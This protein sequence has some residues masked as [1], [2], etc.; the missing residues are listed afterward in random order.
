MTQRLSAERLERMRDVLGGFVDRGEMPGLVA[1]VSRGADAHVEAIGALAFGG[2]AMRRDAIFRIA[3]M[4]KPV[5]A[6]AAMILVEECKLR[7]DDAV[8]AF[9]PELANRRVL[10]RLDGPLDDTVP[11]ARA[12]T[13]RDLLTFRCGVGAVMLPPGSVP[14]QK[15]MEEAGLA[16]GPDRVAHTPDSY[17]KSL[18]A[19]PLMHQ[20]G[21]RWMYHTGSD[22]LGVLITRASGESF[23]QFLRTRIFA[24]LSMKDTDFHVPAEKRDRLTTSYRRDPAGNA[25]IV[26]D[27]PH[28]SRWAEQPAFASGGGGLVSTADDYLAFCRMMLAKGRHGRT[29]VLSR[30]AVELM[31]MDHLTDAQKAGMEMFFGDGQGGFKSGWGF[32]MGIDTKRADLS[33]VPGRFGWTGGIGTAGLAD[34]K[35]DLV[36]VLLT[37][38]MMESPVLPKVMADFWTLAYQT[39]E[40]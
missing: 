23:A 29:R 8:D 17:M 5:T 37:Q 6:A 25:L 33:S 2:A 34:P 9:L 4:T 12:I 1:L 10:C 22:I 35:E 24:P 3:S 7:L 15:A 20:P 26:H 21:E 31:T 16:P 32:G 39:M 36:G 13:L 40:D 27:D 18:G 14:I 11:A 19:L 28:D 38:R 30:A